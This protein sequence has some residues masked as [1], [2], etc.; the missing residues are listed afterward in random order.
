M[1]MSRGV[2]V[3]HAQLYYL[4]GP[5]APRRVNVLPSSFPHA[6]C[7]SCTCRRERRQK[8]T[9][10]K[11]RKTLPP[12]PPAVAYVCVR[13]VRACLLHAYMWCLVLN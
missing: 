2:L 6:S 12:S 3:G 9:V 4:L 7:T 8:H 5:A 1:P 13:S 11:G 10:R